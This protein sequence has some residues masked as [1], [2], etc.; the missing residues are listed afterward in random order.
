MN[1]MVASHESGG[2]I[3]WASWGLLMVPAHCSI[4]L[5]KWLWFRERLL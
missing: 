2:T 4:E 1:A 5:P 3:K